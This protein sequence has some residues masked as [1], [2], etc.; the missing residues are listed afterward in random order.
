MQPLARQS[1]ENPAIVEQFQVVVNGRE[2]IKAYSEL[3]DPQIQQANFNEQA[4]A[5]AAGDDEATSGDDTFILAMEHGMPPQSG[6]GMGI[7]RII[8]LLTQQEN[9]RDSILFP[10]MKPQSQQQ[11]VSSVYT[12]TEETTTDYDTLPTSTAAHDLVEKYLTDTKRHC[13]QVGFVMRWF[14]QQ[15]GENEE[16][17]YLAGLLHDIDRDHI[18]KDTDKHLKEEFDTIMDE[19]DAPQG[20]RDDIKSHGE[21]LTG[22]PV[23]TKLRK[24]LASIDELSGFI[25]A[26]S[27]MRPTGFEGMQTK[28]VKKRIKDKSFAAGVDR[29][30]LRH[31][32]AYLGIEI[33]AFIPQVIEAL[34]AWAV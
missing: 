18:A 28:G 1:D 3:V 11:S 16:V 21:R 31:C 32:E 4:G 20:L 14:A 30:H 26:Y 22:V 34:Q 10:L 19:I 8:T 24:Y 2:I 23:N 7:D 29:A 25:Y 33:G 12:D 5:L 15:L 13:E 6:R 17:R 9:L 27:L